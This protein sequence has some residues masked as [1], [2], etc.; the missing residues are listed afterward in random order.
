MAVC[1]LRPLI[2]VAPL[3]GCALCVQV[4]AIL[5]AFIESMRAMYSKTEP[6]KVGVWWPP[7]LWSCGVFMAIVFVPL[8]VAVTHVE[9]KP[10][11]S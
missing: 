8:H 6:S 5:P 1:V 7:V 2:F 10:N 4:V 3:L 11:P 9:R